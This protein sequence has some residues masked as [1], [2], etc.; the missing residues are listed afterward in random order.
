MTELPRA[1][2]YLEALQFP[3]GCFSDP[4]LASARPDL[5]ALG[6]PKATSGNVAVVFRM[7]G[8]SGRA[9]A[10]RCF[11]RAFDDLGRRYQAMV[12]RLRAAPGSWAVDVDYRP[13]GIRIGDEWHPIVK[14]AWSEAVPLVPWVEAHLWD[15]AALS[16]VAT[17]FASLA[18]ELRRAG[19]AHGDLQHG[20]I[21]V[22]PGGD[23]RLVDYD[24]MW[25]PELAGL[26]GN[27]LGHRNY[28]HPQRTRDDFGPAM[29]GFPSWVVY[30]SLA[31]LSI[32]PLLW[33]RLDGGDECLLFRAADFTD[34]THSDA[35]DCLETGGDPRLIALAD[36]LRRQAARPVAE[37]EPLSLAV[38][39]PPAL[40]AAATGAAS[41]AELR[42]RQ[43]LL[44]VLRTAD[45]PAA[46]EP[47]VVALGPEPR[48]RRF[49]LKG[50]PHPPPAPTE[51]RVE[52]LRRQ[53]EAVDAEEHAVVER[54]RAA[55][56]DLRR[57][58]QVELR[59]IDEELRRKLAELDAQEHELY[60]AEHRERAD[61]LRALH[62]EILDSKLAGHPVAS[63]RV[64]GITPQL[65]YALALD[66]VRTAADVA[67][68]RTD[69]DVV[70]VRSD[71]RELRIGGLGRP[72]ATA[73]LRWRRSVERQY[74]DLLPDRLPP[75]RE[76]AVTEAY[77]AK[78]AALEEEVRQARAEANRRAEQVRD[79]VRA[80]RER[81]AAELVRCK[82]EAAE[83]RLRVDRELGR[84]RKELAE[85]RFRAR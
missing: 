3:E 80:E 2:D 81:R 63:A 35:L 14:M 57:R 71:G 54:E 9:W 16:Y 23:L 60:R 28:A 47:A 20:N 25:V 45:E 68:I 66:D 36:V 26:P 6:L 69:V 73:L 41:L 61:A 17:R 44:A 50:R 1:A 12:P 13:R 64:G 30:A 18:E 48:R 4:D 58:E 82:Q 77:V 5:T 27:E 33:G 75:E 59:V 79:R 32:D 52:A 84:A 38:A 31:A 19:I 72:Q 22:A 78:R 29:D 55:E 15:S 53:R 76:A 46:P 65:V 85:A 24:G 43:R 51:D 56:A 42:E 37:V 40:T 11:V 49:R 8:E 34:S 10:V 83:G 7:T 74:D 21:L 67:D 62:A 39:P 70:L